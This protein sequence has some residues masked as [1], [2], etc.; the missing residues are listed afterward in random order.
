M[1]L[2]NIILSEYYLFLIINDLL[3]VHITVNI[4]FEI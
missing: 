4:N 1:W 2:I 3:F